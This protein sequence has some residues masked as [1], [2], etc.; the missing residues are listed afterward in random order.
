MGRRYRKPFDHLVDNVAGA[1]G[2]AIQGTWVNRLS[3]EVFILADAP[4]S[5]VI[6]EALLEA[7]LVGRTHSRVLS[8]VPTQEVQV[9]PEE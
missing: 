7:G 3:H 4:N 8:V 2:I 5:H 1:H 6:E 9:D